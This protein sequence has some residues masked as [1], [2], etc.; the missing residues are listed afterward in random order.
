MGL[1]EYDTRILA[2]DLGKKRI[3][4]A[5][6]DPT[7][8]FAVGLDTLVIHPKTD[9]L[10]ELVAVC[11]KHAV[12]TIIMGLPVNMNGTEGPQAD[13]VRDFT[14]ALEQ[15]LADQELDCPIVFLDE[16]LTSVLAQQTLRAQ[17]YQP[18][19]H[20][21]WIDQ[22]SAKRILQDYLDRPPQH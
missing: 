19:R 3:G 14:N 9:V 17:G 1:V 22:A 6:S 10:A 13:Y 7:R 21:E 8:S 11:R 20:K 5:I 4:L 12:E 15:A 2:I 18:S 16:R